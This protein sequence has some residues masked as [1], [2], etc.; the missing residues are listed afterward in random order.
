MGNSANRQLG[1]P[2]QGIVGQQPR[3]TSQMNQAIQ[4]GQMAPVGTRGIA[5]GIGQPTGGLGSPVASDTFNP[6]DAARIRQQA[7]A[8]GAT[9]GTNT[10]GLP[11]VPGMT[12]GVPGMP[13]VPASPVGRQN[14]SPQT[15]SI[16][17]ALMA[18]SRS[19]GGVMPRRSGGRPQRRVRRR[20]NTDGAR[21][22]GV[23]SLGRGNPTSRSVY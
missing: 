9:V 14:V 16:E 22:R 15:R 5:Q 13:Q 4:Q 7:I 3:I 8:R 6:A 18:Q 12:Q 11:S 1:R 17:N 10:S 21:R 2:Q 23:Q 19:R 20:P